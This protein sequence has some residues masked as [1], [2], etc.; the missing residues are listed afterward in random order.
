MFTLICVNFIE[1]N[2]LREIWTEMNLLEI[3]KWILNCIYGKEEIF[4]VN[5]NIN[6]FTVYFKF[7]IVVKMSSRFCHWIEFTFYVF[8][9][10]ILHQ[11]VSMNVLY[12]FIYSTSIL[13]LLS[14]LCN[15]IHWYSHIWESW[16][17]SVQ[18]VA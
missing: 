16:K 17:E 2:N 6:N 18:G 13:N 7:G 10:F 4:S 3:L 9:P 14:R 11:F 5:I 12:L 1:A 15:K 8:L